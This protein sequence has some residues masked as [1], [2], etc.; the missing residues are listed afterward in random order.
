MSFCWSPDV[1]GDAGAVRREARVEHKR[2][3]SNRAVPRGPCGPPT[4]S[5]AGLRVRS[6]GTYDQRP[7]AGDAERVRHRSNAPGVGD[8]FDQRH[9]HARDTTCRDVERHGE[10]RAIA[11]RTPDAPSAG[12]GRHG[13]RQSATI[14]RASP[15][16]GPRSAAWFHEVAPEGRSVKRTHVAAGQQAAGRAP[17][18]PW[19]RPQSHVH[20][21]PPDTATRQMPCAPWP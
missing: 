14:A 15:A 18:L 10:H 2:A 16:T 1:E 8:V 11:R 13:R 20:G 17:A 7:V 12:T 21:V 9:R 6:P 3:S 4:R 19:R 5:F